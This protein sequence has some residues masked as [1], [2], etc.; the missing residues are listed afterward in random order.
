M[1]VPGWRLRIYAAAMCLTGDLSGARRHLPSR[2][3]GSSQIKFEHDGVK[4]FATVWRFPDGKLGEIF[5]GTARIGQGMSHVMRDL[6]IAASLALQ[7]G[8]PE[9]VLRGALARDDRGDAESPLAAVMDIVKD[10]K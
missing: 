3:E 9:S 7:Y 4:W 5:V 10:D 6:G 8:C 1:P 2:R